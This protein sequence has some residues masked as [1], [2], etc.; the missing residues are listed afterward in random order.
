M[1][2]GFP[3]L[4]SCFQICH[5]GRVGQCF[6]LLVPRY[7]MA[8]IPPSFGDLGKSAKDLFDKDFGKDK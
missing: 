4:A 3:E 1:W 5:L 7:T 2:R 6:S 8:K